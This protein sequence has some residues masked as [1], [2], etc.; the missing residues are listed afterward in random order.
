VTP[1]IDLANDAL[2]WRTER[3]VM[4]PLDDVDGPALLAHLGD[5]AVVT[6]MDIEPLLATDEALEIIGW[7]RERRALN[8]GVRWSIRARDGGPMV[9]TCGFNT[10][11]RERG[12]QGEIAYDVGRAHWGRRVMDEILPQLLSFGF[13]GLG[14]R[15]ITA[16]VTDGNAPSCRLLERHG[17]EREGLLRDH[18][19]WKGRFWDQVLYARLAAAS[20]AGAPPLM[21]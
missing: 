8:L 11:Q 13:D 17:F 21:H 4:R 10:I 5:P 16:L 7:A 12:S 3:F 19:F 1:A 14:L 2:V 6:F 9:G 18:G 15:R 20:A